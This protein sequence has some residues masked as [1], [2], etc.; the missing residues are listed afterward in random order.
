VF[1]QESERLPNVSA[2]AFPGIAN[3]ALLYHLH[4]R[5]VYASI[6]GGTF[7]QIGLVLAASGI[8]PAIAHSAVSFSLSRETTEDQIDRAVAIIVDCVAKLRKVSQQFNIGGI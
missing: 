5:G 1:F 8:D 4:R 3:E 6:G 7:Q 2:I